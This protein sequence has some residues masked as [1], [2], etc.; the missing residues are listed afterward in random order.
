MNIKY[1]TFSYLKKEWNRELN[2]L[3]D[4]PLNIAMSL[5]TGIFIGFT[6]TIGFQTILCYLF[7][8]LLNLSFILTFIGSSIPTGIPYLIPFTYFFCYKIGTILLKTKMNLSINDFKNLKDFF[9][10]SIIKIGK[11]LVVGC[12]FCAFLGWILTFLISYVLLFKRFK[13]EKNK[14]S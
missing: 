12:F 7:S 11:P 5:S 13:N 8:K 10:Y 4:R 9:Y 1:I 2:I 6:P 3:K 14:N